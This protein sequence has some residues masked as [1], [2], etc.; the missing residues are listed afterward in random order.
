MQDSCPHG[1]GN[2]STDEKK[3]IISDC[4]DGFAKPVHMVSAVRAIL[5]VMVR[6]S[7]CKRWL[8]R[9]DINSKVTA[10]RQRRAS[11]VKGIKGTKAVVFLK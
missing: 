8:L 1:G 4:S 2:F 7:S 10:K 11:V 3:I 6:K 9:S 5:V